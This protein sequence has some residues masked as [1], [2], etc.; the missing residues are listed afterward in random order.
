MNSGY[1]CC[2]A[3][4]R[5]IPCSTRCRRA[6]DLFRGWKAFPYIAVHT[7]ANILDIRAKA[8][9][10]FLALTGCDTV[11]SF[12]GRGKKSARAALMAW[13]AATDT[14]LALM[15]LLKNVSPELLYEI[16]RFVIVMYS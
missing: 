4:H 10:M 6:V 11:S 13:P 1:G 16:E 2:G 9:V 3:S 15:Y 8:L 5:A 7:L 12:H 14:L